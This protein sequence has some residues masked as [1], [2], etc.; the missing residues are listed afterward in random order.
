MIGVKLLSRI[1]KAIR[2]Q[3]SPSQIASGFIL[4]MLLGLLSF[5]SLFSAVIIILIIILNVNI[6][7]AV[8]G[9]GLF[10]LIAWGIDPWLHSLG[11]WLLVDVGA[12]RGL[13]TSLYNVPVFPLT[14]FNNTVLL[15]SLVVSIVLIVPLY[16]LMKKF[17]ILYREKLSEK[18]KR[19][20]IVQAIKGSRFFEW[21]G[22]ISKIGA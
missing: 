2:S 10:R 9:Y 5:K 22:R 11:Y 8:A 7:I 16:I 15:G 3:A 4:G 14:R 18:L 1:I 6:A 21:I 12:L 17:V 13:W 19:W 20:K